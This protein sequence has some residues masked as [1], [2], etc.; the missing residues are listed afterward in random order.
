MSEKEAL[1]AI[2]RQLDGI[3]KS[4]L[5]KAERNIADILIDMKF[6]QWKE[7]PEY[8]EWYLFSIPVH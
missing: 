7:E 6:A 5:T 2:V 1:V 4:D 3:E 8:A